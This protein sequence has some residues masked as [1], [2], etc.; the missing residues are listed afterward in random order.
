MLTNRGF[1]FFKQ[2]RVLLAICI[3]IILS[4]CGASGTT[5]IDS[6]TPGLFNHFIVFPFSWLMDSLASLF[7]GSYGLAI[8]SLTFIVRLA[9][10]PLMLKQFKK[11]QIIKTKMNRMK[12]EL[13]MLRDKYKDIDKI[14]NPQA[15]SMQQQETME[16]YKQHEFNPLSMGCLPMLL[17]LPI[18]TGLYYAIR[19]S[20]DLATHPFLWFQLGRPDPVLPFIAALVSYLQ[21]RLTQKN[22]DAASR[23]QTRF[24]G[25]LSPVMMGLFS[26]TAPAALPL[27]WIAGGVFM[28]L[29]T[30]LALRLYEITE[31]PD[32]LS[33]TST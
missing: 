26:F 22:A 11:Q 10:L 24:I 8:I 16:L 9:L 20:P 13:D 19:M 1:T 14:N 2:Y 7:Q 3:L 21:F 31:N 25:L 29:Q 32:T 17:Q 5:I 12:P 33:E 23:K 28:I 18:L 4:G 30:L 6:S 27:Y 15:K